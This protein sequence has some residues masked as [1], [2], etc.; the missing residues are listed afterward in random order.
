MYCCFMHGR[1]NAIMKRPLRILSY[2]QTAVLELILLILCV[3]LALAAPDTAAG[4]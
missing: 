3:G 4:L 2:L 1:W